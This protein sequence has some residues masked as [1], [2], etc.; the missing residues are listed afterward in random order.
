MTH[1]ERAKDKSIELC[2]LEHASD[3][4]MTVSCMLESSLSVEINSLVVHAG[5][6]DALRP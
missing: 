2:R 5:A 3:E 1:L 4:L 6:A